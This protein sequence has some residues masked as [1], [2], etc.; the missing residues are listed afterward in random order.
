MINFKSHCSGGANAGERSAGA[1]I[2]EKPIE[3]NVEDYLQLDKKEEVRALEIAWARYDN[4]FEEHMTWFLL[5]IIL[6]V[7]T[8]VAIINGHVG[9]YT[10]I[11]LT[12]GFVGILPFAY[13]KIKSY[14]ADLEYK[15]HPHTPAYEEYRAA[16]T[17]FFRNE[18][19]Y[20]KLKSR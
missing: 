14:V 2:M 1:I 19:I 13:S 8:I 6:F 17:E 20:K 5:S 7:G 15:H 4:F 18:K 11:N 12:L 10:Y 9:E 3:P 16:Y